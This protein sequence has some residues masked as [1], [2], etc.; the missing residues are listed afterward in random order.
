MRDTQV[1]A[2]TFLFD[3]FLGK[4]VNINVFGKKLHGAGVADACSKGC[5]WNALGAAVLSAFFLDQDGVELTVS[6]RLG[7][8]S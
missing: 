3:L 4:G 7:V 1:S 6:S 5:T 8:W 2:S